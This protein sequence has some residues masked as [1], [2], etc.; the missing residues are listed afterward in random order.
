M[1]CSD[2]STSADSGNQDLGP[3]EMLGNDNSG[4]HD[5]NSEEIIGY[6]NGLDLGDD[7]GGSMD[8]FN[9]DIDQSCHDPDLCREYRICIETTDEDSC[10]TAGGTWGFIPN[11]EIEACFC[12]TE[13]ENRGC[14]NSNQCLSACIADPVDGVMDCTGV[15]KGKCAPTNIVV[16]CHCYFDQDG[17]VSGKCIG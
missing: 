7:S 11:T 2:S 9:T 6:D 5:L 15:D 8:S 1:D 10:I 14:T 3:D 17:N 16:G 13:Q 4:Q 12:K